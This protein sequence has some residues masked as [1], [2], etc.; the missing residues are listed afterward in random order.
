MMIFH[1]N[2]RKNAEIIEDFV[3]KILKICLKN[4]YSSILIRYGGNICTA[5]LTSRLHS[6]VHDSLQGRRLKLCMLE[7][8]VPAL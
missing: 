2:L 4:V 3:A 5:A 8:T 7:I 6:L 1:K